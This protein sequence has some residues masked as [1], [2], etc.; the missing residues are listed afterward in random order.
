MDTLRPEVRSRVMAAIRSKG[1]K[2]TEL[3]FRGLLIRS[4]L[5]GW[6][7]QPPGIVGKPDFVFPNRR[8]AIFIDSCYWHG[9]QEHVRHPRTRKAYW[10][11]KIFGNVKRDR[12]VSRLLKKQGWRIL[13]IWEHDLSNGPLLLQRLKIILR[14]NQ[15]R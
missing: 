11:A 9:C 7:V 10:R 13:R 4:G 6:K 2:S 1:N 14:T 3:R 15:A 12:Y 5:N 8:L